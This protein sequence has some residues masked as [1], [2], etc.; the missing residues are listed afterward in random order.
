MERFRRRLFRRKQ[1]VSNAEA[2]DADQVVAQ[3]V[4]LIE[5]NESFGVVE[6][7]SYEGALVFNPDY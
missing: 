3:F 7:D 5:S 6:V 4:V 1:E 2:R